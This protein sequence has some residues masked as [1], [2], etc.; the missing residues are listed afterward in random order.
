MLVLADIIGQLAFKNCYCVNLFSL[1][2]VQYRYYY[3]T[4]FV[5]GNIIIKHDHENKL[6]SKFSQ[7]IVVYG[8]H[9]YVGHCYDYNYYGH[10]PS[11]YSMV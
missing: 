10:C 3:T 2:W 6:T 1:L 7:F 9:H 4:Y 8:R 11:V 5:Q